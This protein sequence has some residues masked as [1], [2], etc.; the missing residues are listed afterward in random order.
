MLSRT[1]SCCAWRFEPL[2][3]QYAVLESSAIWPMLF[4]HSRARLLHSNRCSTPVGAPMRSRH[5][6]LLQHTMRLVSSDSRPARSSAPTI[7]MA[8]IGWYPS[9]GRFPSGRVFMRRR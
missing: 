1:P 8:K 6:M 9:G 5:A 4:R 2:R 3:S 7:F